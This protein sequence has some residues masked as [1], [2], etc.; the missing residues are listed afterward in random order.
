MVG[1][2][3]GSNTTMDLAVLAPSDQE[4]ERASEPYLSTS[5]HAILTSLTTALGR[6]FQIDPTEGE[7]KLQTLHD[8]DDAVVDDTLSLRPRRSR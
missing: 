7:Y 8:P 5:C 3:D 4:L 1:K 2:T 6:V